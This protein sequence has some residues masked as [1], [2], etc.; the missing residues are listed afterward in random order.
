MCIKK[1]LSIYIIESMNQ[2]Q[3]KFSRQKQKLLNEFTNPLLTGTGNTYILKPQDYNQI[4]GKGYSSLFNENTPKYQ[5]RK[6]FQTK[7]QQEQMQELLEKSSLKTLKALKNSIEEFK[8]FVY[9]T[10]VEGLAE[11]L[12]KNPEDIDIEFED[13]HHKDQFDSIFQKMFLALAKRYRPNFI[14]QLLGEENIIRLAT[15][16]AFIQLAIE[17]IFSKPLMKSYISYIKMPKE[18]RPLNYLP[19]NFYVR[20]SNEILNTINDEKST[21]QLYEDTEINEEGVVSEGR[22]RRNAFDMGIIQLYEDT[23]INEEGVLS[24]GRKRRNAIDMG[25]KKEEQN[26]F[27]IPKKVTFDDE[28]SQMTKQIQKKGIFSQQDLQFVPPLS[29]IRSQQFI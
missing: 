6:L 2:Q 28:I 5:L 21:L 15:T 17:R 11:G 24:E 7:R 16:K 19:K 26:P 23:E 18:N 27:N 3:D 4:F 29:Q 13:E 9:Y 8:N 25:I 1:K 20:L 22:K 14:N 12:G 10:F